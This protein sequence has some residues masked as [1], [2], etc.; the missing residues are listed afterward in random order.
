MLT[1][2]VNNSKCQLTGLSDGKVLRELDKHL[3]YM[4]QSYQFM[5]KH[6]GWDGRYRLFNKRNGVFPIGMLHVVEN[7]LKV[8][9]YK[10]KIVDQRDP[11]QYGSSIAIDP[12]SV[13]IPR[14]YQISAVEAAIKAESGILRAATGCHAKGQGILM[15]DGSIKAV[16]NIM[17]GDRLMGPD[18]APRMVLKLCA[19]TDRMVKINP[20]KGDS[21][22][23]NQ[24]HVLSLQRTNKTINN[25]FN[26]DV[27]DIKFS[28]WE[29]KSK[30]FKH[31]HKL[32]RVPIDFK[33]REELATDP[34]F[35]GLLLG[36]GSL[37]GQVGITTADEVIS[38]YIH[39]IAKKYNL[40]IRKNG[41]TYYFKGSGK[42]KNKLRNEL[43]DLK[44][45]GLGSKNKYIPAKYKTA[46]K[47]DRL[48]ILAGLLDSDGSLSHGGFDYISKSKKLAE[49]VCFLSRSIGLAA[50]I[51]K[52][53]K[54]IRTTG[55]TGTYFRVSISG[56]CSI[57][58]TK[59]ARKRAKKRLQK[60]SV[61]RT[62][63]SYE[64]A[65]V[66]EYFGFQVDGDNRYL[67]DDFTVTHNSGKSLVIAM[68]AGHYNVKTVVYVIGKELLYQMKSTIEESLGVKCGIVG[69][70]QCDIVDGIN[71]VTIWSA[72]SAFNKKVK[73]LDSDS[74]KGKALTKNMQKR[75]AVKDLVR[76]AELFFLDECQ[77]AAAETVQFLHKESASARHR[78]L[79]S[80]TPWRE[81]GDDIL[82]E[83]VSGPKFCDITATELIDTNWLVRPYITFINIPTIR[84]VG[85]TYPEVYN[86]FIVNNDYR[87]FKIA[88]VAKKMSDAG[89]KV[90]ILVTKV[91]HGKVIQDFLDPNLKVNS[92]NGMNSTA[93]RMKAIRQMRDGDLDVMIASRIFDQG[94]DIP[95]LDALILA[96]SGKST[97]RALQ[98]IGRVIRRNEGKINAAVVDFY[99]NCKYL[100]EHSQARYRIYSSEPGFKIKRN[101]K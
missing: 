87:N 37:K 89:R 12:S 31:I 52:C 83:A 61:L 48:A 93:D 42:Y 66:Q 98:R 53:E 49:D 10:Y 97:A 32:F 65:G 86:N 63:F 81:N 71:I 3:S 64:E 19:G 34:Y 35:L 70:G 25:K 76:S 51:K 36:D 79:L 54:S 60:K 28:D 17:V 58:P 91:D 24:E 29:N 96:G 9:K 47:I 18:S 22:I 56:D 7:I 43:R 4:V 88:E 41:I 62:D 75:E 72:A 50:Y 90:L 26:G 21:F 20:V 84:G 92:L 68:I 74:T 14:D 27:I 100:R 73:L 80:G 95:E 8:N 13:F 6:T 94:I 67:L 11:L 57:I 30:T 44:L 78:F 45:L 15:Y 82:I 46:S 77:Y 69:D 1:I 85:K 39:T 55:F 59:L 16:E 99:D 40:E 38:N 33:A 2:Y 23:I 5:K 101:E